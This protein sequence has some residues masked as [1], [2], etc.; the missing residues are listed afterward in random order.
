MF[1]IGGPEQWNN[2]FPNFF[3]GDCRDFCQNTMKQGFYQLFRGLT[4]FKNTNIGTHVPYHC[5][6]L[7]PATGANIPGLWTQKP[8]LP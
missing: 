4:L 8:G 3:R 1:F 2:S 5:L 6:L 7:V